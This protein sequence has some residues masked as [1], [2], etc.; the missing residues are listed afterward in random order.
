[1]K[2]WIL[3]FSL[4]LSIGLMAQDAPLYPAEPAMPDIAELPDLHSNKVRFRFEQALLDSIVCVQTVVNAKISKQEY[5]H[6][7]YGYRRTETSFV[8]LDG[9]T[10]EG[11][12]RIFP[13]Y[14]AEG[15][16]ITVIQ[17]WDTVSQTFKNKYRD[18][19]IDHN[20]EEVSTTSEDWDETNSLWIETSKSISSFNTNGL[21]FQTISLIFNDT[22]NQL[23]PSYKW[24]S[25]YSDEGEIKSR[26]TY[27]W[28]SHKK[29]WKARWEHTYDTC[30]VEGYIC[31]TDY[32]NTD[33]EGWVGTNRV[34]IKI[35]KS[36]G[37]ERIDQFW[38]SASDEWQN[39]MRFASSSESDGSSITTTYVWEPATST[40]KQNERDIKFSDE[41]TWRQIIQL[42]DSSNDTW[43]DYGHN[44]RFFY[45]D[46]VGD[47]VVYVRREPFKSAW[48]TTYININFFNEDGLTDSVYTYSNFPFSSGVNGCKYYYSKNDVTPYQPPVIDAMSCVF[49]NP[50]DPVTN[51]RCEFPKETNGEYLVQL[52][53]MN[54][55][56]LASHAM[57]D[58]GLFSYAD[59]NLPAG[60]YVLR[61]LRGK[62]RVFLKKICV[63]PVIR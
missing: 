16:E 55:R 26:K 24:K 62:E 20:S 41:Y 46:M 48:D 38:S 43:W 37:G 63:T 61:I 58:T 33:D 31:N 21:S 39:Q 10:L 11:K 35:D 30:E 57:P 14:A 53:D 60:M 3:A 25:F 28:L 36:M 4:L 44:Y 50:Y 7:K 5:S 23:Q 22:F 51:I 19:R 34:L 49:A 42:W 56:R 12:R 59:Y 9:D 29:A 47:T 2:T 40:W 18:V 15:P 32:Y 13:D 27:E 17:V 54:G 6:D 1:M 8:T 45:P 52:F